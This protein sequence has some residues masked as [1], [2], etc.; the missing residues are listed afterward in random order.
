MLLCTIHYNQN[1]KSNTYIKLYKKSKDTGFKF[2]DD[3]LAC[4][5]IDENAVRAYL[6]NDS[7]VLKEHKTMG[8]NVACVFF[9]MRGINA[10]FIF[11]RDKNFT[12]TSVDVETWIR[13]SDV[14]Y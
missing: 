12:Y 7:W 8:K 13:N 10:N 9:T 2:G 11:N 3:N 14:S 6:Q 1:K 4:L 5:S